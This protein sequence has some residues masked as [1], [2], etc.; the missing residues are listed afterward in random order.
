MTVLIEQDEQ[1]QS[2]ESRQCANCENPEIC[3]DGGRYVM[4]RTSDGTLL[5][6]SCGRSCDR[7]SSWYPRSSDHFLSDEYCE[8]CSERFYSCE[9]CGCIAHETEMSTVEDEHWCESCYDCHAVW[10]EYCDE[11][12]ASDHDCAGSIIHNYDYRPDPMFCHN[13]TYDYQTDVPYLGME[14]EV[15]VPGYRDDYAKPFAQIENVYVKSDGSLTNGFEI[16]THPMS[17]DYFIH[18]FPWAEVNNLR[19]RGARS[20]DAGT[21]G[22]HV[23]IS[24]A[25]FTGYS[26]LWLFAHFIHNN[27]LFVTR[28][29][30]RSESR[31]A[32]FDPDH[33]RNIKEF[34][35][36]RERRRIYGAGDRYSAVNFNNEHTLEVR[37]FRGSLRPERIMSAVDFVDAV[38]WYTKSLTSRDLVANNG[39]SPARFVAWARERRAKYAGLNQIMDEYDSRNVEYY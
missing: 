26:H 32:A 20:W 30:G 17:H 12:F 1:E 39:L 22:I 23:H 16:V 37:V 28:I 14:L 31:W 36:P 19:S 34:V 38:F 2:V 21:C 13:S 33:R 25:A 8:P 5:C 9:R 4:S 15:E 35:K 18:H 24:R 27:P 10:C 7:C 6:S 11:S 29:A 3:P